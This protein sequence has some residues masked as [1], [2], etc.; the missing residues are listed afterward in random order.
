MPQF[1]LNAART[2]THP[3]YALDDFA[4]GYVEAMFFTNGDTGDADENKLNNLGVERLTHGAIADI[5]RD[6]EA[7]WNAHKADLETVAELYGID[8]AGNDFWF[9]RQGHGV[10][11]W[12]RNELPG[13]VRER[14]SDA[15]SAFG[16]AYCEVWRG[17]IYH[18]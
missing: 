4:K 6:C 18:R 14:L 17:W 11:Y 12:Y 10:G 2:G 3:Y 16:E 15:A 7:F 8:R 9:T 1:E 5:R 13:D